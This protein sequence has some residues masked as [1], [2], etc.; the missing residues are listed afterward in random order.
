MTFFF[1]LA[2]AVA[3]ISTLFVIFGRNP[4]HALLNLV[5][6]LLAVAGL[7]FMLGAPF[8]GALEVIVYAGAIMV[9]FVFVVMMLNLGK[10]IE[11]QE[12]RWLTPKVWFAPAVLSVLLLGGLLDVLLTGGQ[13]HAAATTTIDAKQ[14]GVHLFGPYLLAVELGSM[15]LLAALVAAYHLGRHD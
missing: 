5:V 3:V 8:A 1:Y 13:T 7:F 10:E 12:R 14:V 11:D 9:L 6:S 4:V 2:A 15:L